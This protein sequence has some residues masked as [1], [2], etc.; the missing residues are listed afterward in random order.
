[1][2][3]TRLVKILTAGVL[4]AAALGVA[5]AQETTTTTVDPVTGTTTTATTSTAGTITTYTPDSDYIMFRTAPDAAPVRYYYTKDT[6]IVDPEGHIVTWSAIR[7]DMPATVYY[8]NVGD[9][10]VVRKIVLAQPTTIYK[11]EETT[12]TTTK[13]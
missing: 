1:M 9:R 13:P 2:K 11:K 8:T 10:I 12:T 6:T 5:L 4:C 3:Q 7:P